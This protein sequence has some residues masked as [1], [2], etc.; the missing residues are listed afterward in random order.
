[1]TPAT[2]PRSGQSE[3]LL[4]IRPRTSEIGDESITALPDLLREG[5]VI[6]LNDAATIPGSL[7]ARTEAGEPVEVRLVEPLPAGG[8]RAV[9]L[10]D[11]DWRT[12]TERRAPPPGLSVGARLHLSQGLT[13]SIAAVDALSERLVELDFAMSSAEVWAAI[14]RYGRP[15]Q[16]AYLAA[17]LPLWNVQ[18]PYGSRPWAA[19]MPSAGR[20]LSGGLLARLKTRGV[21]IAILTHAAGLS[22]TGDPALD[23]A[24]P[25]AERYEI[26]EATV[27]AVLE[28]RSEGRRILAVGTT[29]VRALEGCASAHGGTLVAGPGRTDLKLG[30]RSKLQVVNGLL[31]GLH[32]PGTSHFE[33]LSA[34]APTALVR[35]AFDRAARWGYLAHEFGDSQLVLAA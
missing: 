19:E 33:L 25:L 23:A 7:S 8:W 16:Y 14:Y 3:R 30:P 21:E 11:G 24:L 22:A 10:G 12:P 4:V 18:T 26:P 17:D 1:M 5:D 28:A 31:S 29:V 2:W 34:F 15:I 9:L 27:R 32:E 6:V 13:A 35:E 20:P